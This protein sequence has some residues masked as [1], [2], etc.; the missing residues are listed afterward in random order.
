MY[1]SHETDQGFWL[2]FFC[3][4]LVC[5]NLW[6]NSKVPWLVAHCCQLGGREDSILK[7]KHEVW[8]PSEL[9]WY[10]CGRFL[11][12]AGLFIPREVFALPLLVVGE[13]M[14]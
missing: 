5:W 9:F 13:P 7:L 10:P 4:L 3:T 2:V 11:P 6:A 14:G 12:V 8:A 1:S